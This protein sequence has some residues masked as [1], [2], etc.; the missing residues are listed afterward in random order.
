VAEKEAAARE[1]AASVEIP[2]AQ[3]ETAEQ[4]AAQA[5]LPAG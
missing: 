4:A 2:A 3:D 1:A 5:E